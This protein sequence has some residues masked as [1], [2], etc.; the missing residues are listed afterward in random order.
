MS[1]YLSEQEI[2]RREKLKEL[3]VLGIDPYPAEGF[4]VNAYSREIIDQFEKEPQSFEGKTVS[5]AGRIMS[6]RIMGG[7][8][9]CSIQEPLLL[10]RSLANFRH[11][12]HPETIIH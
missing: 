5:V 7:A 9:F 11:R 6:K 4:E 12:P 10:L 2:I 1:Q 3:Q 8:S